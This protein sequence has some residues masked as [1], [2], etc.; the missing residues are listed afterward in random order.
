MYHTNDQPENTL[1][2]FTLLYSTLTQLEN[3]KNKKALNWGTP[4]IGKVVC[5]TDLRLDTSTNGLNMS[6]E[7]YR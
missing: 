4:R 7:A 1:L 6:T 5:W 3:T 2:Y